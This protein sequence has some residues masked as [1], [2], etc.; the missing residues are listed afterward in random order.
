MRESCCA[1]RT[2]TRHANRSKKMGLERIGEQSTYSLQS[3]TCK[4]DER[5]N[6]KGI[7]RILPCRTGDSSCGLDSSSEN[8]EFHTVNDRRCAG[9]AY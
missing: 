1:A 5:V 9:A 4:G 2:Y 6:D 7:E 8:D 3:V